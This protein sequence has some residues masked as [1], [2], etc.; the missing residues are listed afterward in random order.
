M[1]LDA[2]LSGHRLDLFDGCLGCFIQSL[3]RRVERHVAA[4][5][6]FYIKKIVDKM[7]Q[8]FTVTL[9]NSKHLSGFLVDWT[10]CAAKDQPQRTGY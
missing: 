4:D 3:D 1:H 2:S 7:P 10:G 5:Q 9:G 8:L 6:L